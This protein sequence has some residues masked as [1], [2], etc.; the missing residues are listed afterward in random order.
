[1]LAHAI[2]D[3]QRIDIE[4]SAP[5]TLLQPSDD[6][7]RVIRP[8]MFGKR[9]VISGKRRLLQLGEMLGCGAIFAIGE[10][11]RAARNVSP[12]AGANSVSTTDTIGAGPQGKGCG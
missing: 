7:L 5:E 3:I 9:V 11:G 1:M 6:R 2:L 4:G 8:H 10:L 12:H